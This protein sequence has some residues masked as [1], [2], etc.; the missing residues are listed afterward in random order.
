MCSTIGET[1]REIE[2]SAGMLRCTRTS[3]SVSR[4]VGVPI[5]TPQ[6][7]KETPHCWANVPICVLRPGPRLVRAGSLLRVKRREL[8]KKAFLLPSRWWEGSRE[9]LFFNETLRWIT[10]RVEDSAATGLTIHLETV[11]DPK[12]LL[13]MIYVNPPSKEDKYLSSLY[14]CIRLY[15]YWF[16]FVISWNID[17]I[18]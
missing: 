8:K 3:I 6:K 17:I 16:S 12:T 13:P 18:Y 5:W 15:T 1:S 4:F 11:N 9:S 2:I 7:K 14:K 10:L